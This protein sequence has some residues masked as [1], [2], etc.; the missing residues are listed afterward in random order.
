[1]LRNVGGHLHAVKI[2][3]QRFSVSSSPP[4]YEVGQAV[5]IRYDPDDP[6]R[7]VVEGDYSPLILYGVITLMCLAFASVLPIVI[8]VVIIKGR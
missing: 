3:A 8:V 4:Q 5:T 7:Y 2:Y 1:M 6:N